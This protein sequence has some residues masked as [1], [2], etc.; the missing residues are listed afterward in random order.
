[1]DFV[2]LIQYPAVICTIISLYYIGNKTAQHRK[3]GFF[4]SIIGCSIWLVWAL[5]QV[6]TNPSIES[7][8]GI[9]ITNIVIS[10]MS[11]RGI[12]NNITY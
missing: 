1:M 10:A 2:A 8:I 3:Y 5:A 4:I 6:Y 11:V 12:I 9:A 7:P